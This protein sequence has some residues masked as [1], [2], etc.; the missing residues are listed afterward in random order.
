MQ[1]LCLKSVSLVPHIFIILMNESD[2]DLWMIGKP[3]A[4]L[5]HRDC[6]S[7][8]SQVEEGHKLVVSQWSVQLCEELTIAKTALIIF[9]HHKSDGDD[10]DSDSAVFFS[11][12]LQ[13][14]A[15]DVLKVA[16]DL[17]L[18]SVD[19]DFDISDVKGIFVHHLFLQ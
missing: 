4:E 5:H 10:E 12:D 7:S 9:S 19:K 14:L 15:Q 1:V 17:C 13:G 18:G 8:T 16:E 3:S 2:V 11:D 6:L